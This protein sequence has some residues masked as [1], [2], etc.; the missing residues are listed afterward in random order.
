MA[1]PGGSRSRGSRPGQGRADARDDRAA[2]SA[3]RLRSS[4]GTARVERI[5]EGFD[6]SEGPVWDRRGGFLLFSDVPQNTVFKWQQG[7]GVNVFL[8]PSGYTGTAPEAVSRG[9]TAC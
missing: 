6:W 4:R 8:K 7:K 3:A 1:P 5:A 2:R 9:R